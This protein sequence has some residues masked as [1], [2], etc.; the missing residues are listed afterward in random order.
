MIVFTVPGDGGDGAAFMQDLYDRYSRLMF[1]EALR[2][3]S[4]RQDCEDIVQDAVTKLCEKLDTLR[5]L[6]PAALPAYIIL[7]VKHEAINYLR[8]QAVVN[9]H[10]AD[11]DDGC[12]DE[13]ESSEPPPEEVA[14]L[15]EGLDS[16]SR[17]W[18]LLPEEDQELLY[19]KYALGQDNAEL[20]E[21]FHCRRDSVR[22]RLTRA[23][24]RAAALMK[25]GHGGDKAR[26]FA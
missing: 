6:P 15:R 11:L 20:A 13:R 3:V 8:H 7:T 2:R 14:E 24:R 23:R 22:M 18:P 1:A 25:G 19:R 12:L 26:T 16:L 4:S 9:R 5:A 17:V 10:I 21:A